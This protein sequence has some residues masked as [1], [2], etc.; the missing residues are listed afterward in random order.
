VSTIRSNLAQLAEADIAA[1]AN[2]VGKALTETYWLALEII[3]NNHYPN[4]KP[5][6]LVQPNPLYY[7]T[8][9]RYA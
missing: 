3:L 8:S 9:S 7:R 4:Q 6:P 1:L 5:F 2:A